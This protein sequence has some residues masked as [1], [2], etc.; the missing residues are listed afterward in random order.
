MEKLSLAL[1][2]VTQF[3][4]GL[5]FPPVLAYPSNSAVDRLAAVHVLDCYLTQEVVDM[6]PDLVGADKVRLVKHVAVVLDPPLEAVLPPPT[7]EVK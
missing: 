1:R 2:Q 5:F 7:P 6:F 4:S 3:W